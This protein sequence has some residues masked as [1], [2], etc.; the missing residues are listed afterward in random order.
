M[1]IAIN[2]CWG[3]FSIS[4]KCAERMAELGSKQAQEELDDYNNENRW[5]ENYFKTG[6]WGDCPADRI[7]SLEI[8]IKYMKEATWYGYGF[9]EGFDDRYKR[10]DPYLI[11]AIEELGSKANGSSAELKIVDIPEYVEWYI[12]EYDGMESVEERHNSWS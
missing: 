5:I 10:T 1:K 6:T 3:G 11:Q 4:K 12:N 2:K 8:H 7:S 9:V